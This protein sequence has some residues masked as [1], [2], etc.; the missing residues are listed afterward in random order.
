L[1]FV[2]DEMYRSPVWAKLHPH[3]SARNQSKSIILSLEKNRNRAIA[4]ACRSGGYPLKEIA[5][6][7][8]F[9]T[10]NHAGKS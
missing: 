5:S 3:R 1:K 2:I 9:A 4:Q 8:I 7:F 10:E 6:H